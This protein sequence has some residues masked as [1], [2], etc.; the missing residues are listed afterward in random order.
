MNGRE[1]PGYYFGTPTFLDNESLLT[2]TAD[3]EK[4]KYFKIQKTHYAP[5][6]DSKYTVENVKK[7]QKLQ[8]V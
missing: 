4:G 1:I 7:E 6:P 2:A 8:S 3:R 5:H